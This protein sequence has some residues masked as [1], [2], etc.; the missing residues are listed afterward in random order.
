MNTGEN[1]SQILNP[2]IEILNKSKIQMTKTPWT[3]YLGHLSLF[4][5]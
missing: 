4:R 3:L 5:I 1:K 2:N